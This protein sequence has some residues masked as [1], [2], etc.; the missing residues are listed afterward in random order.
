MGTTFTYTD[1][2]TAEGTPSTPTYNLGAAEVY[3]QVV[4]ALGIRGLSAAKGAAVQ[5]AIQQ[6]LCDLW[7]YRPWTW[8]KREFTLKLTS[9]SVFY[10]LPADFESLTTQ[11]IERT[12][13]SLNAPLR[14]TMV[15]DRDFWRNRPTTITGQPLFF[16]I[17]TSSRTCHSSFW[18][19]I[20]PAPYPDGTYTFPGVEYNRSVPVLTFVDSRGTVP[21][22]PAEFFPPWVD[23]AMWRGARVVGRHKLAG[24]LRKDYEESVADAAKRYDTLYQE[25]SPTGLEDPYGD[26]AASG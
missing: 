17:T 12:D 4:E 26:A 13:P 19:V 20:E 10:E 22:M 6:S 8:R 3:E 14:M 24:V 15:T 2:V 16:R 11:E 23:A 18:Y 9:S 1:A 21:D 5:R 25:A 7:T